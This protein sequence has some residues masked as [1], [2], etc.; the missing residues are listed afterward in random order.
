M[1]AHTPL[2][3]SIT[4]VFFTDTVTS[5]LKCDALCD[6]SNVLGQEL[7]EFYSMAFNVM[8]PALTA[9][10]VAIELRVDTLLMELCDLG[11]CLEQRHDDMELSSAEVLT[12]APMSECYTFERT[13]AHIVFL[14]VKIKSVCTYWYRSIS[15]TRISVPSASFVLARALALQQDRANTEALS[16]SDSESEWEEEWE[17]DTENNATE[18]PQRSTCDAEARREA[19]LW[20]IDV[21]AMILTTGPG[22]KTRKRFYT[23][24]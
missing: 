3:P 4:N 13:A 9:A 2:Q 23:K 19:I 5:G 11:I 15:A 18:R 10:Q 21:A 24:T 16:Y 17:S 12:H 22:M 20:E 7:N 8:T 1:Q 14:I 6:A